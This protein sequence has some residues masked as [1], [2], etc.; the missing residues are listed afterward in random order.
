MEA[1]SLDVVRTV[2][3]IVF[4]AL[5]ARW[6]VKGTSRSKKAKHSISSDESTTKTK[7]AS[8]KNKRTQVRQRVLLP[9]KPSARGKVVG[10]ARSAECAS[11]KLSEVESSV[12]LEVDAK[13]E[14]ATSFGS[15]MSCDDCSCDDFTSEAR[16]CSSEIDFA[17]DRTHKEEIAFQ[18]FNGPH[19]S[20]SEGERVFEPMSLDNGPLQLYTDGVQVFALAKI[21]ARRL[22]ECF[23]ELPKGTVALTSGSMLHGGIDACADVNA[24][25]IQ[26]SI[27]MAS[28]SAP[29]DR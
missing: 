1:T 4:F 5:V 25:D 14:T 15:T 18:F 20:I 23:D 29:S 7:P 11:T 27:S 16:S 28:T 21:P 10:S 22:A 13:S 8:A 24:C 2:T 9:L 19:T 3:M 26:R 12:P 17:V 6:Y